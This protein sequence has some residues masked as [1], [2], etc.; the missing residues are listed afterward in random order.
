MPYRTTIHVATRCRHP[1]R[2]ADER[3]GGDTTT[4]LRC[5]PTVDDPALNGCVTRE[6]NF[7]GL[8][9]PTHNFGAAVLGNVAS[10]RHAGSHARP[11]QA[12]L[13]SLAKMR[14]LH[15][16]GVP[17]AVLPPHARPDLH[18][19]RNL[20]FEGSDAVVVDTLAREAPAL[21]AGCYAASSMWVANAATATPSRDASD[22]KVHFSPANLQQMVHRA[23]EAP[24][25]SAIFRT[26]F[27]GRR[28]VH[29]APLPATASLGD[30]G[31]ANHMRLAPSHDGPGLHV[32]VY[33]ASVLQPELRPHRFPARQTLEA[34]ASIARRHRLPANQAV[35][36]QQHPA[37]I[38]A[39]VFHNDVIA[40]SDRDRLII[41]EDA[42]IDFRSALAT[43]QTRYHEVTNEE[44]RTIVVS[45][46][47]VSLDR[48]IS[49]Y[50]FNSQLV[51]LPG[52]RRAW[53]LPEQCLEDDRV[54]ALID[55]IVEQCADIE[56]PIYCPLPESMRGGGGP[57]CL[58]LRVVLDDDEAAAVAPGL[59]FTHRLD[60]LLTTW[61]ERHYRDR[62]ELS[63]LADP[64]L[65]GACQRA[66]DELTQILELGSIYSFQ[67]DAGMS[68]AF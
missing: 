16:L 62:L 36:L 63:D 22:G 1:R 57:A 67:R 59:L 27:R 26:V 42:F 24:T 13:E 40:I 4:L 61:I 54:V 12:A 15:A 7:D 51:E 39:G 47:E 66:L 2:R 8:V 30:E 38:D 6:Y 45:R 34:S 52:Q 50:L 14:A 25:T 33:G 19:A 53:L 60:G 9:G 55:R 20:G 11:R 35:F 58:R 46:E 43:L 37:A 68:S 29:H 65:I 48:A 31:A 28:F 10:A 23:I 18:L 49:T 21:L 3:G 41:H 56:A 32:F 44:L 17:Q 5:H 64:S